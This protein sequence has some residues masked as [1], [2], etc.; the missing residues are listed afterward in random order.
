M[1]S[2]KP[3]LTPVESAALQ[4]ARHLPPTPSN[5]TRLAD[6]FGEDLA[7]WAVLQWAL[8]KRAA[9]KFSRADEMLF[10]E[11]AL[12]QSTHES[13]ADYHASIFP[14]G[15]KVIDLTLGIGADAMAL[16]KRGRVIGY[17]I[18]A[19]RAVSARHNLQ[20]IEGDS[21]VI[22]GSST[23]ERWSSEYA[24]ADPSRRIEGK[25]TLEFADMSPNPAILSRKFQKLRI[26][27]IK[28]SPL[29]SDEQLFELGS[30]IEFL[31][32][33]NECR[34]ALILM[35]R[36]VKPA[37]EA[38]HIESGERLARTDTEPTTDICQ[39]FLYEADP[40]AIRAHALGS[41]GISRLGDSIG[42]LTTNDL[43]ETPWLKGFRV[44]ESGRFDPRDLKKT[45]RSMKSKTPVLKQRGPKLD[46]I[47]LRKELKLDGSRDLAVA[48][49]M[50]GKSI[51]M[52]VLEPFNSKT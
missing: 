3:I 5:L 32:F 36:D 50:V 19:E 18:D 23:R 30:H 28:M 21:S 13:L 11:E 24:F 43:I 10:T 26:G 31:S 14:N 44:L 12:E 27:A 20:L 8:R 6:E 33:K 17:E 15:F 35:G 47:K 2:E 49:F 40:A 39:A 42:Y 51:R 45:L 4:R 37:V 16:K 22:I 25:R 7:R 41:F 46:L 34:E 48:L 9:A 38:V 29:C 52:A 1:K